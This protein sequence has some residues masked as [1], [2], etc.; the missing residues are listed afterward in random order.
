MMKNIDT[1]LNKHK[2]NYW[3]SSGTLLGQIRHGGL[4]PWDDDLDLAILYSKENIKKLKNL[5]N[6]LHKYNFGIVK[7]FYGYKIYDL[8]GTQIKRQLWREHKEKF[9]KKN[10]H[11][12]GRANI[13]KYA[14]KTYKKSNKIL[15][16]KYRYPFIDIFLMKK[17]K[18]EL[19]YLGNKWEKCRFNEQDLFPL[20]NRKFGNLKIKSA[21]KPKEYLN[22]CYG[23]EWDKY[24]LI[25][26]DHKNERMIKPIKINLTKKNKHNWLF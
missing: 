4:I 2:I 12:K 21:K 19:V 10:P 25:S 14:S 15:Y 22:G 16:E 20:V 24:G 7:M 11:I 26:Y 9:K 1:L 17:Q 8:N 6:D 13:S 23:K 18:G 5:E 3:T